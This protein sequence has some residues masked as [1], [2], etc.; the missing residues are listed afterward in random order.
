[1]SR[2]TPRAEIGA[3]AL[4]ASP[5]AVLATSR[6]IVI[7]IMTEALTPSVH[8]GRS[9]RVRSTDLAAWMESLR[10]ASIMHSDRAIPEVEP[11]IADQGGTRDAAPSR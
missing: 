6:R 7:P 3:R 2:S 1:M 8:V 9:R 5:V 11:G 10:S 4:V